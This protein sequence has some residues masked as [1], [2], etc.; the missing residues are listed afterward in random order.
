MKI[1]KPFDLKPE[2]VGFNGETIK[3]VT[4]RWLIKEEDGAQNYAMRYFEMEPGAA[5]PEHHHPWEHEIYFLQGKCL[6]SEGKEEHVAEKDTAVFIR[7]NLPHS[8]K[9]IGEEKVAFICIIPYQK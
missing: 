7:P 5:I 3:G 1:V 2:P 9:N 4:I 6:V 8:Y